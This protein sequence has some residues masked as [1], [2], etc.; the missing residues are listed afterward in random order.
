MRIEGKVG[1]LTFPF[2]HN[3]YPS[4]SHY[5]KKVDFYTSFEAKKLI[6]KKVTHS[7]SRAVY[8]IIFRPMKRFFS[9]YLLKRGFLDGV[10]GF[11][12]SFFDSMNQVIT[13]GKFFFETKNHE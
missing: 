1:M 4:I 13:Y 8:Y 3:P 9:R 6:E 5:L 7:F 10:P 12:A 11:L 2:D